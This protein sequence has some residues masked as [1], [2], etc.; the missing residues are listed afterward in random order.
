MV[1][2]SESGIANGRSKEPYLQVV[3]VE[4]GRYVNVDVTLEDGIDHAASLKLVE[5]NLADIIVSPLIQKASSS[6]FS[7][8]RQGRLMFIFRDPIDRVI[9]TFYYLQKATWEPTYNP[10]FQHMTLKE[11]AYSTY[12]ESNFV[13][14][15]LLN[16]MEGGA[17]TKSDV[18]LCKK[19]L[20]DKILIG[21][22]D[23]LE[24]SVHR[25]D[26]FFG[27]TPVYATCRDMYL[28][29]GVNRRVVD[30]ASSSSGSSNNESTQSMEYKV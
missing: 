6:L 19:I 9:S 2:A 20:Q 30:P 12:A 14:R 8:S 25:F 1:E 15:S 23:Q 29:K 7:E 10:K 26:T 17:L 18:E 5:S 16:K 24:E 27:F 4:K 22:L 3:E 21:L 28:K 11:Y 13:A